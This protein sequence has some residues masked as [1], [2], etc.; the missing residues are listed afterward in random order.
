MCMGTGRARNSP[1]TVLALAGSARLGLRPSAADAVSGGATA[2]GD[3]AVHRR[4]HRS[5]RKW[6]LWLPFEWTAQWRIRG[7]AR[8]RDQRCRLVSAGPGR[9]R[10]FPQDRVG[11]SLG[12][13]GAA[14]EAGI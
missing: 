10:L 4:V 7:W 11:G 9:A 12:R 8:P 3:A 14:F 1:R 5:E 13:R 6:L 2:G